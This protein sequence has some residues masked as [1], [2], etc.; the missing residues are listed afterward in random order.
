MLRVMTAEHKEMWR[1]PVNRAMRELDRRFF[2]KNIPI[3]AAR[4]FDNKQISRC[5]KDLEKNKDVLALERIIIVKPDP[6]PELART[7][8]KCVLLRDGI[9][10]DGTKD[11]K[12]I[13]VLLLTEPARSINMESY[14]TSARA[15]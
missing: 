2:Q 8:R 11:Q 9:A 10:H 5:R 12:T 13:Q 6:Q 4:V 1:P 14:Y 3:S 15:R 7:G